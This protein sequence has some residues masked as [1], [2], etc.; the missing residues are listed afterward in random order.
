MPPV[1]QDFSPNVTPAELIQVLNLT[2]EA[3]CTVG[4]AHSVSLILDKL[5]SMANG[6]YPIGQ[7]V[8]ETEPANDDQF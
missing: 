7:I 4:K 8:P 2:A 5:L 1:L 6:K 3:P